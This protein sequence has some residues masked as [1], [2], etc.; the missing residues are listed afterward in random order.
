[1]ASVWTQLI[2]MIIDFF[3][4][5]WILLEAASRELQLFPSWRIA[6]ADDRIGFSESQNGRSQ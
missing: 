3:P 1:M 2:S 4:F 5:G 6:F